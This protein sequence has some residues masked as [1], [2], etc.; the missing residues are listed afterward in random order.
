[1]CHSG[2]NIQFRDE[3]NGNKLTVG[4][5]PNAWTHV[6]A[7]YNNSVTTAKV[8]KNGQ[9]TAE[10][11]DCVFTN[12]YDGYFRLT[13]PVGSFGQFG[14]DE[15]YFLNRTLTD[16]EVGNIY[17]DLVTGVQ[18][19][20]SN[21]MSCTPTSYSVISP[22]QTIDS[23][24]SLVMLVRDET[25]QSELTCQ[26]D[27]NI[28]FDGGFYGLE[29]VGEFS[30]HYF[31]LFPPYGSL[32]Y[33]HIYIDYFSNITGY[34]DR[35][36]YTVNGTLDNSSDTIYLYLVY[37]GSDVTFTVYDSG[38]DFVTDT[39]VQ[40]LKYYPSEDTYRL[41]TMGFTDDFGKIIANLD[42]G[43][44]Y[45]VIVYADQGT[46]VKKM[47]IDTTSQT[48][49]L[50]PVQ[51]SEW[52]DHGGVSAAFGQNRTSN[53]TW[54][55]VLDPSGLLNNATFKVDDVSLQNNL[56]NICDIANYTSGS[57]YLFCNMTSDNNRLYRVYSVVYFNDSYSTVI[58]NAYVDW[59]TSQDYGD[60]GL[61]ISFIII[62]VMTIGG[63]VISEVLGLFMFLLSLVLVS[64]IDFLPV[65]PATIGFAGFIVIL[66][67]AARRKI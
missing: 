52:I 2:G 57:F 3:I 63:I 28:T 4:S 35:S 8:Y 9:K 49:V 53:Y 45:R 48:I 58:Y 5:V 42:L 56:G 13:E 66:L 17:D 44:W 65:N 46:V 11:S 36:Y 19:C 25:D 67:F 60:N 51:V 22:E 16:Q 43:K 20:A 21:Y 12:T 31:Y 23:V 34:G 18:F 55:H 47:Y 26:Y 29:S 41:V 24:E 30:T 10:C 1:M 37:G 32:D 61:I 50:D 40:I 59:R 33:D 54:V 38:Y 15:L 64:A 7:T 62:M 14:I 27:S 39:L 6:C